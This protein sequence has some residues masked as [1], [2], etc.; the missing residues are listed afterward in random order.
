[1]NEETP[2]NFHIEQ[3]SLAFIGNPKEAISLVLKILTKGLYGSQ[4]YDQ[5]EMDR[6]FLTFHSNN[7]LES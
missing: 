4:K 2:K 7:V 5:K 1:M 6:P 3:Q